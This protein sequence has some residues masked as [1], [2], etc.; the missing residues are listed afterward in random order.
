MRLKDNYIRPRAINSPRLRL[1]LLIA[2]GLGELSLLIW[3]REKKRGEKENT[4]HDVSSRFKFDCGQH[5]SGVARANHA[6]VAAVELV[7][8]SIVTILSLMWQCLHPQR[9]KTTAFPAC[10]K[11]GQTSCAKAQASLRAAVDH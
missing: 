10:E 6:L 3:F 5:G 11:Q 1:G 7:T 4:R 2:L 9:M 8:Y